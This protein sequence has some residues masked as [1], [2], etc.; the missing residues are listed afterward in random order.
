MDEVTRREFDQ[1]SNRVDAIDRD[2][3]RGLLVLTERLTE[4]SRDLVR[5][6]E[7]MNQHDRQHELERN[8]RRSARR[9]MVGTA[10]AGMAS[11]ATVIT[12]LFE[13]LIH[14]H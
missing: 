5:V 9:W 1:L 4:V 10:I 11:M 3:P 12:M 7:R 2:G 14:I 6:D 13:I 8:D